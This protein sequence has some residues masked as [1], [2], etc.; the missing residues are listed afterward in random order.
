[1]VGRPCEPLY[2][3]HYM[4]SIVA[5][6]RIGG[7]EADLPESEKDTERELTNTLKYPSLKNTF[8]DFPTD[9]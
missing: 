1:M 9:T 4:S 3:Y 8:K 5:S 6:Q 7:R 2:N